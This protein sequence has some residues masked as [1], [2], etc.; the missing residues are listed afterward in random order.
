MINV[1]CAI[2]RN[3]DNKVLVVQRDENTDHP[4]KWEFPGGKISGDETE[5]QCI[6]REIMEELSMEIIIC[7]RLQDVVHDYGNKKIRLIPFVCD[8]LDEVPF[9]TGHLAYKWLDPLS[10]SQTDF[11]EAD[12]FVANDYTRN[13]LTGDA[14]EPAFIDESREELIADS[15]LQEMIN[16]LMS[17]NEAK[18]IAASAFE[19]EVVLQKLIEYSFSGDKKLAFRAS[20][21]V[22][23]A[24][25]S[26]P[27][28]ITPYL[29]RIT[30]SLGVIGNESVTR[31]FLRILSMIDMNDLSSDHQGFLAD[32]CFRLLGSAF[33][34]IAVKAYSMEILYRLTVI[35]PEL[36]IELAASIRNIM[37]EGSAGIKARGRIIL[38]KLAELPL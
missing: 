27:A 29:G 37:D 7:S 38:K 33:S 11:S 31:S 13:Y 2:I 3:E 25:D 28:V 10:L 16:S 4:F 23:K 6:V 12:V 30:D 20:W 9:L 15:A 36:G 5:E 19:N 21:I 26:Y 14:R 24:F 17:S 8:T 22:S 1:T 32:Y 35:Y 34:A 18:W